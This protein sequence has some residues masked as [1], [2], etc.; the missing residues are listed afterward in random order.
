M[1][2]GIIDFLGFSLFSNAGLIA[3][4]AI[5]VPR[6]AMGEELKM[7]ESMALLA[8]VFYIFLSVNSLTYMAMTTL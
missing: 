4:I 3:C 5:F 1:T 8:M 6:W 2:Q 7:G